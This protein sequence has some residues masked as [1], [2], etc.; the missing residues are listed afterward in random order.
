M[1]CDMCGSEAELFKASIE[2]TLLNVCPKCAKYG[3]VHGKIEQIKPVLL[4]QQPPKETLQ[5]INP[6]FA[7]VIK[8]KRESLDLK[9]EDMAKAISE[10]VSLIHKI[11][12]GIVAPNL[13]LAKKLESFLRI[14]LIEDFREDT[15]KIKGKKS[16]ELTLGDFVK[17]KKR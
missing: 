9:Q 11:E 6:Q 15:E 10:K 12:T 5:V 4:K 8:Q 14:K 16:A 17:V 13:V 7:K 2:G 3:K 1:N